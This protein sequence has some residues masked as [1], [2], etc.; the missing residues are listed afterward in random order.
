MS[1]VQ[2]TLQERY[3][4]YH[5]KL[6]D[7]SLREI[8]RRL[9]RHHSTLAREIKRNGPPYPGWIYWHMSAQAEAMSTEGR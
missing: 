8:A 5:L 9:K 2:L 6:M 4:L 1:Y 3:V 7:L